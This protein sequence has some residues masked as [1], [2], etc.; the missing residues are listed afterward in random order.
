M[1]MNHAVHRRLNAAREIAQQEWPETSDEE[2]R[3]CR[4]PERNLLAVPPI[5][6]KH[7]EQHER[8]RR[9]E[10]AGVAG[11]RTAFAGE[12]HR[13]IEQ[14]REVRVLAQWHERGTR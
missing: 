1:Q 11:E 7:A 12:V 6:R 9:G 14:A 2:N 13:R 5:H 8:T 3:D 4:G 10:R